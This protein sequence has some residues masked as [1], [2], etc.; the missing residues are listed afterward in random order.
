MVVWLR[1]QKKQ[2]VNRKR[3]T[4]LMEIL[5]LEAVYPKPKLSQPGHTLYPYLLEGVKIDRVDQV[6]STDITYIRLKQGFCYLV[7]VLDWYSRF[8]LSWSLSVTLDKKFCLDAL[9]AALRCGRPE[10]FNSDQAS[11]FTSTNFTGELLK[12]K[13]SI[14]MDG[15]RRYFD[16]IF[17]ERLWRLLKQEEVYLKE[18]QQVSDAQQEIGAWIE[19]YNHRRPYQS[20]GYRTPAAIYRTGGVE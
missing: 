8:I 19:F 12:R 14:S 18:Y 11:Q 10:V 9:R 6:W 20:L 13:I 1:E 3:V 2:V 15:R 17:T 7:A 4:R 16:N 5:G